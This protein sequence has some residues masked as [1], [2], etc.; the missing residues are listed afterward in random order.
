MTT[1]T[2]VALAT[3]AGVQEKGNEIRAAAQLP[4]TSWPDAR[5]RTIAKNFAPAGTSVP[6]LAMFLAV[7]H[8]YDLNPTLNEI[9]LARDTKKNR[10]I[11]LTGRDAYLKI[12]IKDAGYGGINSGVVYAKDTFVQTKTGDGK[13]EIDHQITSLQ[14]RGQIVG[15]YCVA[16][17]ANRV[18]VTV[19]RTWAHYSK[20]HAKGPW[21]SNPDDMIETRVIV[22]AL[23]RQFNISGLYTEGELPDVV[24]AGAAPKS[25]ELVVENVLEGE[26]DRV[27]E[28][29]DQI[30][31]LRDKEEEVQEAVIV[32]EPQDHEPM[33]VG[34]DAVIVEEEEE[35]EY[36]IVEEEVPEEEL[37]LEGA[38]V[39]TED[40]SAPPDDLFP[41]DA[42]EP[43]KP[44]DDD[45]TEAV[46]KK[47]AKRHKHYM[48][49]WSELVGA[50][51]EFWHRWQESAIGKKT[52]KHW[53][54]KD[55]DKAIE[56]VESG[57]WSQHLTQKARK[58]KS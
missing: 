5:I 51:G 9:W 2:E 58:T 12:A 8:K 46:L 37:E 41:D 31:K 17:H 11:V 19:V 16:Y 55:Y 25:G 4:A 21:I 13:V 50:G 32:P 24:P 1:G 33:A 49:A 23:R 3:K 14:D 57:A 54:I 44:E 45:R 30:A 36:E 27:R 34:V 15:A 22:A 56:L 40:D 18:P 20:L 39:D 28:L 26:N 29:K 35:V 7:A 42:P 38:V 47:I 53:N 6:E 48:A 43:E 52:T 10:L